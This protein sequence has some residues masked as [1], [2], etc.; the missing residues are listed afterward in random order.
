MDDLRQPEA[1]PAV[2]DPPDA[3][4]SPPVAAPLTPE[5]RRERRRDAAL[6][7]RRRRRRLLIAVPFLAVLA[8][9][10]VSY[11]VWMLQ[12]TSQTWNVRSVEWVRHKVP[13]GNTIVDEIEHV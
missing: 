7:R 10:I 11:T 5:A 13:F 8:W 9:A 12:P 6:R 2:S 4:G 1:G 3:A